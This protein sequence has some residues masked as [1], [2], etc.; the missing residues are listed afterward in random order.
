MDAEETIRFSTA[1]AWENSLRV[2]KG[3][4]GRLEIDQL[5][6]QVQVEKLD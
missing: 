2:E 5:A 3:F 1:C 4:R 6:A